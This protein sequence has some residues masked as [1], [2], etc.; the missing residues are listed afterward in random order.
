LRNG[1]PLLLENSFGKG[2]IVTCLTAAGPLL[3]PEGLPWTNWANGPA[4][5]SYAVFQ[6]DLAK[7]IARRDRELPQRTVGEPI[8]QSFQRG[9]FSDEVEFVSPDGRVTQLRA[10]A[11]ESQPAPESGPAGALAPLSVNFRDTDAPG[12][13]GVR[14]T[15]ADG[16]P[17]EQLIAYNVSAAEGDLKLVTDSE[18]LAAVGPVQQLTIQAP[19][20]FEWIRSEAPGDDIRWGL[21]ALLVAVIIGEQ[22][23]AYRLS[24]HPAGP[25]RVAAAA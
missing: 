11:T 6:L 24:Y 10:G 20:A 2:R 3:T 18:L 12:I 4:A 13:Y 25:R 7:R 14:L 1:Q 19:G 17:Q 23:L 21:L 5:P 16:Q 15:T 8:E 22:A 9:Q